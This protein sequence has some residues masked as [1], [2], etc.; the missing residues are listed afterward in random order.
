MFLQLAAAP[1]LLGATDEVPSY[2]VVSHFPAAK[3]TDMPGPYRGTVIR[4]HSENVI[5]TAS[6]KIDQAGVDKM[7]STGIT[8]LTGA[9]SEKDA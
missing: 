9:K 2:K 8:S 1:A 4:V 3:A 6:E 5:D 7:L